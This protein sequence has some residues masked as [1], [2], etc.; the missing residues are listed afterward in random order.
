ML[1]TL[2][3]HPGQEFEDKDS[4]YQLQLALYALVLEESQNLIV[5]KAKIIYLDGSEILD[6]EIDEKI[7]AKL[8]SLIAEVKN[9]ILAENFI[10]RPGFMC[11]Y[12]DYLSICD[13]AYL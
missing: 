3:A 13:D 5:Q 2:K 6:V 7:K 1:K 10:A 11:K 12:C 8:L 4:D 9:E